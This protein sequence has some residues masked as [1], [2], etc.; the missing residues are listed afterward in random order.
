MAEQFLIRIDA[1]LKARLTRLARAEGKSASRMVREL[2][3]DYV[4]QRDI[5]GYIDVL[6]DGIRTK[7]KARGI[8]TSDI[9][10]AVTRARIPGE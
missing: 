8:G 7:L 4:K 9:E 10:K 6:W 2:I 3:Q 5:A 1:D